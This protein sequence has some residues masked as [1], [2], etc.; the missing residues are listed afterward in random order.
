M[1]G[2]GYSDSMRTNF[3]IA[4]IGLLAIIG[5]VMYF[6]RSENRV[7][8]ALDATYRIDGALVTLRDGVSSVPAAPGSATRVVT[9]V[10]GNSVT[11]D[12]NGDGRDDTAFIVSQDTGGSGVFYY[13]VASLAGATSPRGSE[14]YLLGDRIAPQSTVM[15]KGNIIVV[16]YATRRPGESFATPPSQG[17]SKWLLL[18]PD[19]LSW[20]EVAQ[21]FEGEADPARMSLTMQTWRWVRTLYN[22]DTTVT[23]R[24]EKFTLTFSDAT[25]FSATTDCNGVGGEY[26]AT[27]G[28]IHFTNMMSTMMYCDGSEERDFTKMLSEVERYQ[29][30]SKGELILELKLDSGS[31][32][33]R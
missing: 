8:S 18:D 17:V 27:D 13:L 7:V 12:L 4:V 32:T 21:N 23:P 26:T 2:S 33:F 5:A 19:T 9:R 30:T 16:N 14:G 6:S 11:H 10:F 24:T 3:L 22:N 29:F 28:V 1:S 20:G 31:M 25:H 15:G